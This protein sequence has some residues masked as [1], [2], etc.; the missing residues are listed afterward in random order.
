[1][2]LGFRER[3]EQA[4]SLVPQPPQ[5]FPLPAALFSLPQHP[6]GQRGTEHSSVP[7]TTLLQSYSDSMYSLGSIGSQAG[8]L[9]AC[10]WGEGPGKGCSLATQF[11]IPLMMVSETEAW[12]C[13]STHWVPTVCP[14]A[15]AAPVLREL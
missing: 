13:S 14:G 8:L 1:M 5:N 12:S 11:P 6:K 2:V 15:D 9:P 3:V 7:L 4:S 10:P